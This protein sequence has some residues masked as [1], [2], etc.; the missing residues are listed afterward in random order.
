MPQDVANELQRLREQARGN[1]SLIDRQRHE[2]QLALGTFPKAGGGNG[3]G[4][5]SS[6]GKGKAKTEHDDR[7]ERSPRRDNYRGGRERR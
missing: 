5:I 7:R 2:L 4:G 3:H 1:Q 6:K